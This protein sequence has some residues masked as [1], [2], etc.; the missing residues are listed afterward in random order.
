MTRTLTLS[1]TVHLDG[2][3]ITLY[4]DGVDLD[5]VAAAKRLHPSAGVV[6]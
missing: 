3:T 4:L 1:A 6:A 5:A 2:G